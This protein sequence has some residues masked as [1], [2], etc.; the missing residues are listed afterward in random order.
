M[1]QLRRT[2]LKSAGVAGSVAFAISAGL[3]KSGEVLAAAWNTNAF[4][5]KTIADAMTASGYT[6]S[7]ESKDIDI[8]A[9]EIAENGQVVPVEVTSKIAGTTSIAIFVEK[10]PTPMVGSFD[11]MGAAEPYI[12]TRIKM[13]QTSLVRVAVKA[14]G[15]VYSATKEVKV[16]I[17]GCG[18]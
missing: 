12:S 3:L 15:K 6:G 17:G 16:T 1:D 11:L 7:V 2:F 9:P 13:G 10:N 5:A 8:K 4:A 14:G 18:G